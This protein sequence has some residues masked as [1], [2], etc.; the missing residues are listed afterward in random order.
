MEL[1]PL[2][3]LSP[4][5]GRYQKKVEALRPFLS[6]YG[7]MRYRVFIEIRW[8]LWLA[9]ENIPDFP[10]VSPII[11]KKLER[12]PSDFD[13]KQAKSIKDIER[14]TNHDVKAV[15]YFL[16]KK[17]KEMDIESCIPFVHFGCTSE[18]INNCSYALM[19]TESLQKVIFPA[20][21]ILIK[22]LKQRAQEYAAFPMLARTHGQ[23]A[24]TT[25]LGKEF[26]NFAARL[27]LIY[28]E[29]HNLRLMAK[30]NGAVGNFNAHAVAYPEINW[31]DFCKRFVESLGLVPNEYTTQIEPHDRLAA[32]L[33]TLMR[34]NTVLI[35]LCRDVWG[36]ISLGYFLQK[37]VA[38]EI[39]SSTMPHKVNPIDFENAEGN[40]GLANALADHLANK[41]PISR[42]QRDL[43]DSTALRNLG[44]VFGYTLLAYQSL[45]QGFNKITADPERM[46]KELETHWEILAE[47][48]QTTLRRYKQTEAYETLKELTRGKSIDAERIKSFI[49]TLPLPTDVKKRLES[50]T[51]QNYLGYAAS[52][53]KKIE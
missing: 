45:S 47:A 38:H 13:E 22:T 14:T 19:I 32:L 44:C 12:I 11:C 9:Q 17:L 7:L 15:E 43:T 1:T 27:E 6:E 37:T 2:T 31:P 53:A 8:L 35:D 51:P 42:W 21:E 4:L 25:T 30:M 28:Q 18:D 10:Q 49:K 26:A 40:L 50:L 34:A 52:L 20:L 36:Y 16:Q 33:Q 24:S 39:G 23:P 46:K 3:A 48:I 29:I 41:L 5:D